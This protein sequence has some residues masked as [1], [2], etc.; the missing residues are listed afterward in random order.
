MSSSARG[1][2]HPVRFAHLFRT[3]KVHRTFS[4]LQVRVAAGTRFALL[5]CF[6][7]RRSTGPSRV[8]KCAWLLAPGSLCSP[9]SHCEGP[10]DLLVSSSARGR[11]HPV[12]FAHLFR[13]AKVHRTFSCLQVR[14]AAGTRFALLTCFALRRS[15][16]PSR[17]FKCAWPLAPGSLCS[18]VSHCEGPQDLLV[19]SS[20]RGRW[21]PVRFAHLFRTAKVHRTF[22]CLQVRVA[23]GTRFALLTCFALRRST[24]P[25]RVFN[26]LGEKKLRQAAALQKARLG[27]SGLNS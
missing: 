17:V 18:P 20:A 11:W 16:G 2:W 1:R 22:S 4:C 6:A 15:T 27:K 23:A 13:T 8:F 12:R 10:Q 25:S 24:G 5:T 3:A 21:H 7:L 19:S 14:V 9:V 26:S